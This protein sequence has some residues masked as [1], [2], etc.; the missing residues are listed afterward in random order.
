MMVKF[1]IPLFLENPP[2]QVKTVLVYIYIYIHMYIYMLFHILY[3]K[4]STLKR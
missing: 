2:V 4:N 1:G 3:S